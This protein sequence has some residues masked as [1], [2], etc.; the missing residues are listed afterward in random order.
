M[1]LTRE[2]CRRSDPFEEDGSGQPIFIKK[3]YFYFSTGN[4][5]VTREWLCFSQ[6]LRKPY[7]RTSWL[8]PGRTNPKHTKFRLYSWSFFWKY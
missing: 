3:H 1:I 6:N 2:P 5:K 4:L 8:F 7:C